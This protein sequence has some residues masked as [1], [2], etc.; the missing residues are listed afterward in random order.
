MPGPAAAAA[1]A[2]APDLNTQSAQLI[3][4]A[5]RGLLNGDQV[6]GA[7]AAQLAGGANA[8]MAHVRTEF[9]AYAPGGSAA[10]PQLRLVAGGVG[11]WNFREGDP[12]NAVMI[13]TDI[14]IDF[15]VSQ[16]CV[17]AGGRRGRP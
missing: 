15:E 16:R 9:E 7:A 12:E 11:R 6:P 3:V 17:Y 10:T 14:S 13:N 2:P 1:E 4:A 8:P 5:F